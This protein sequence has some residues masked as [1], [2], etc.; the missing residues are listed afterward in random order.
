V[1]SKLPIACSLSSGDATT[2]Q[3]QWDRLLGRAR[4]REGMRVEFR[5]DPEILDELTR[6]VA[7]ERECCPFLEFQIEESGSALVL[8]ASSPPE[9]EPILQDLLRSAK[10]P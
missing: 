5:P 10:L 6:L 8:T 3:Q 9:A 1:E 4:G 7:L 2:R